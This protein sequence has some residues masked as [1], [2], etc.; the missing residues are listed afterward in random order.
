V[1]DEAK[2][3][4]GWGTALKPSCE[5]ICFGRKPLI[6]TVAQNV[7]EHGTGAIN[8]DG[9]RVE[10]EKPDVKNIAF[11]A[12]RETEGRADRQ[13]PTQTYDKSQGRWPANIIHD[14]SEEVIAAFPDV[15]SAGSQRDEPGGGSY[16]GSDKGDWGN[17]GIGQKGFRIGDSGSAARFFYTAK[18][19]SDDR[20]GSKHPT[21]KPVDLMQWL[22]RLVTPPGG[23]ILDPFAGTGT[24]AE[25]A[26]R[27]GFNAVL[28]EREEEYQ[29][30]I[31]RRMALCMSGP[32]E[33]KRESIKA[34]I[35]DFPFE[36]GSL[37]APLSAEAGG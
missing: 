17:I 33:R 7:L 25:A 32:D 9:C 23:T 29:A 21:V 2:Q 11:E 37:F 3:W 36:P 35:G 22:C 30:D 5:P 26:F 14:G 6:G 34:K 24:T 4:E 20:L 31:R 19:D 8:V 16:A 27:E 28:I 13:S 10:G 1:L 15:H 18:A 12:W